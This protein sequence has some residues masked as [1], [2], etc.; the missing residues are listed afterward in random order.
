M[1][2]RE[3][4]GREEDCSR[5]TPSKTYSRLLL[6]HFKLEFLELYQ[7]ISDSLSARK[8]AGRQVDGFLASRQ[9]TE[10]IPYIGLFLRDD[11]SK[12]PASSTFLVLFGIENHFFFPCKMYIYLM[13][14]LLT[15]VLRSPE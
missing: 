3:G 10:W 4:K 2:W 5:A 8:Q 12:H 11:E 13:L 6:F 14:L 15:G 7:T 1:L 9:K